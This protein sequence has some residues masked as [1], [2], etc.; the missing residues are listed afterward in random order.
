VRAS[1]VWLDGPVPEDPTTPATLAATDFAWFGAA[2]LLRGEALVSVAPGPGALLHLMN[3]GDS[4]ATATLDDGRGSTTVT[5]PADGAIA[6]EVETGRSYRIT[7]F[8][9][10]HASI[11]YVGEGALAG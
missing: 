9:T 2:P 4:A 7:G 10:L 5:V 1:R 6:L 3:P 8:D 11:S